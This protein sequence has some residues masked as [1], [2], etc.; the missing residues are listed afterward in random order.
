[1]NKGFTL[2]E[3]L[4][5]LTLVLLSV[6]GSARVIIFALEQARRSALRFRLVEKLDYHKNY[7]SSLS[8]A[9]PEL[10]EGGHRRKDREFSIDWQV[11]AAALHLKRVRMTA[12]GRHYSL[13]LIFYKSKFIQEVGK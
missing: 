9:A 11:E 5:S 3:T 10:A 4:V 1:M 6:L 7:L 2:I 12:A 13:P 8:F